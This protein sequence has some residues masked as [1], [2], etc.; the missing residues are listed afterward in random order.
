M[1]LFITS[2]CTGMSR[3][4]LTLENIWARSSF[5][6]TRFSKEARHHR[7]PDVAHSLVKQ[8]RVLG[9]HAHQVGHRGVEDDGGRTENY[10]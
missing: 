1:V 8:S 10:H 2:S 9:H 4:L 6:V 7:S 3:K 5:L